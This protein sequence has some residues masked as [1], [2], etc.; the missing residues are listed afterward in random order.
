MTAETEDSLF[1]L[2]ESKLASFTNSRFETNI[3]SE[4]NSQGK[5]IT[6][7]FSEIVLDN[8]TLKDNKAKAKFK[9]LYIISSTATIRDSTFIETVNANT[10]QETRTMTGGYI[11][12]F[13]N[14][15]TLTDNT[16]TNGR[17]NQ[18]GVLYAILSKLTITS[19][20]FENNESTN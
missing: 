15:M 18:G 11:Y 17:A 19:N 9:N 20:T 8:C 4:A 13:D 14:T 16:F 10:A 3:V 2:L 1:S 6:S 7:V 12:S 5:L